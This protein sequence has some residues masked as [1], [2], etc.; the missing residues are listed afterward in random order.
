MNEQMDSGAE[1]AP[2]VG[3][4]LFS[5]LVWTLQS[6]R[7]LFDDIKGGVHWWEPWMWVS[8]V[9]MIIAYI[10]VP[11][12][13]QLVRLNPRGVSAE[14]LQQT[15]E[16][17]EKFGFLGVITTPVVILITGL[18]IA[19]V[20]YLVVSVLADTS[21]FKK[22]FTIYLYASIVSSLGLLVGTLLTRMKGVE[23]IH[24]PEDA[25]ASF[26]PALLLS[27]GHKILYPILSSLD[28]FY[29]WFY[30]LLAMGVS[31]VFGVTRRAAILAVIPLLLLF[32][33]ISL[34]TTRLGGLS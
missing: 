6:P 12:Q 34:V 4:T 33:L 7:L 21:S 2:A 10:S 28:A 32:V 31:H 26:G 23:N 30:V 22:F 25:V 15:V 13:L 29:I 17:M 19:G 24:A 1:A 18:I 8:I 9:N 16:Q 11:I 27:P 3:G 14:Q 5:R 20:S